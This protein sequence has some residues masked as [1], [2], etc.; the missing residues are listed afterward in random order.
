LGTF[1]R[2]ALCE[3]VFSLRFFWLF[4]AGIEVGASVGIDI[5]FVTCVWD[6]HC[7]WDF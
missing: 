4:G 7:G 3:F 2:L 5:A 6:I 1:L